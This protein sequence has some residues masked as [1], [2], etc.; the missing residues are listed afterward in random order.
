MKAICIPFNLVC[1]IC[2]EKAICTS[3]KCQSCAALNVMYD[4]FGTCLGITCALDTGY[5]AML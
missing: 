5:R 4:I 1:H 2:K 3:F